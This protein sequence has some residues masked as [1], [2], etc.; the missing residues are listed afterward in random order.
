MNNDLN[1]EEENNKTEETHY[2]SIGGA[3]AGILFVLLKIF[4]IIAILYGI[5]SILIG[6]LISFLGSLSND[7]TNSG[8]FYIKAIIPIAI[9]FL[10]IYSKK[11]INSFKQKELENSIEKIK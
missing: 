9:G 2:N 11:I 8:P 5:T 10:M 7:T 1:R 4:G 6:G 3:L